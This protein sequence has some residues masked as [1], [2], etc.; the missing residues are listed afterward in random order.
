MPGLGY[1]LK[2]FVFERDYFWKTYFWKKHILMLTFNFDFQNCNNLC[3]NFQKPPLPSKIPGYAPVL[4]KLLTL[5]N[6][7]CNQM[8]KLIAAVKI[9]FLTWWDNCTIWVKL[10]KR[11]LILVYLVKKDI[12]WEKRNW[13]G[14][15][16]LDSK[17]F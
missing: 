11:F 6:Y 12:Q 10:A 15:L 16:H 1:L 5:F 13:C 17:H 2:F 3:P 14:N 4:I 7:W 8:Q 9:F